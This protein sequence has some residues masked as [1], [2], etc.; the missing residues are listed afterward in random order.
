[1]R[2]R[3]ALQR[4][5]I[6]GGGGGGVGVLCVRWGRRR[7]ELGGG[8]RLNGRSG[9]VFGLVSRHMSVCACAHDHES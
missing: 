6:I 5:A 2:P 1:M 7:R 4:Q 8:G 9:L 3:L